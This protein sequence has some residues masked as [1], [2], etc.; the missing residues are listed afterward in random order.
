MK[1][2]SQIKNCVHIQSGVISP[3]LGTP[4]ASLKTTTLIDKMCKSCEALS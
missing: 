1:K 3:K 4:K 2:K